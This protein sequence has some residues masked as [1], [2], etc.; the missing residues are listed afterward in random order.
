MT[1]AIKKETEYEVRF[2]FCIECHTDR[3]FYRHK[4]GGKWF[5]Q[6]CGNKDGDKNYDA[7]EKN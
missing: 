3:Y 6:L 7:V 4:S 5:C 2:G 1:N